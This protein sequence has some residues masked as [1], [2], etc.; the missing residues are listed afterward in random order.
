MPAHFQ[1]GIKI[2]PMDR[3]QFN[4][5]AV[6]TDYK[7]WDEFAFEFDKA[8][9]VTALARLFTPGATPT[10]LAIPLGFQSTWNLA[11]GV[12]YDLTSRLQLRAGY[13]PR[14]SAIPEDRRSPLVPINEAR[15]Y[16]LGLGYQWDRD[17]QIDLAIATLRSKDTIPSNT[18][19]L[20]NCTG[21]DNV[22]YNPYAGLDIATEATINMVG[23]AFRTSF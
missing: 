23:L 17:T 4:V 12:Q 11:F 6:W 18:S 9:A 10:S 8:T 15:Y 13:E 7:K 1:T 2:R 20:A 16:S 5:D 19:C 21:I 14:A 3:W 22:V